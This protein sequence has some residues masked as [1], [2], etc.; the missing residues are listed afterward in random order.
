LAPT[1][2]RGKRN[3]SSYLTLVAGKLVNVFGVSYQEIAK[4]TTATANELF[5]L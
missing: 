2:Y 1:P 3:Q 5:K 4:I